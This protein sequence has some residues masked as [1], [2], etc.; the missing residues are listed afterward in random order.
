MGKLTAAFVLKYPEV[1]LEVTIKDHGIDM[2]EE[3]YDLVIQ[4]SPD[5]DESLIG[6]VFLWDRLVAMTTLEL[7]RPSDKAVVPAVLHGTGT[8]SAAWNVTGPDG[9]SCVTIRPAVHLS[10]LIMVCDTV[11]LGV[12][13]V[14]LPMLL[15]AHDLGAGTLV[16]WDGVDSPDIV[17]WVLYLF[18]RLLSIR[19]PIFLEYPK[20]A[21]PTGE[22]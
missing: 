16:Y 15:V 11:W 7:K 20:D 6:Q 22:P 17:L 8:E 13:A 3:G 14:C 18:R 5:L 19:V 4:V 10:P 9:T 1:Q 2:I 12:G 21:F